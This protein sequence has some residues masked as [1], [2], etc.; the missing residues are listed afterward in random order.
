MGKAL[1][2]VAV[3][4]VFWVVVVSGVV[5]VVTAPEETTVAG[6]VVASCA[7]LW[8]RPVPVVVSLRGAAL[9]DGARLSDSLGT[10]TGSCAATFVVEHVPSAERVRV[11]VA[12]LSI[13]AD[14]E[15][16]VEL[17]GRVVEDATVR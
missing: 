4:V 17:G 15:S 16:Y 6:R 5:H 11:S 13:V 8:A 1:F 9:G 12:G 7:V 3:W 2:T 10:D 14:P